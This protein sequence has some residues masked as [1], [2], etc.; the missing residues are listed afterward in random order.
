[1][2]QNGV[3]TTTTKMR[4]SSNRQQVSSTS[5]WNLVQSAPD[6][7]GAQKHRFKNQQ[8]G[9]GTNIEGLKRALTVAELHLAQTTDPRLYQNIQ[10]GILL[11]KAQLA[12]A[13]GNDHNSL[14]LN[15]VPD[16]ITGYHFAGFIDGGDFESTVIA[17]SPTDQSPISTFAQ[18]QLWGTLRQKITKVAPPVN[19]TVAGSLRTNGLDPLER[20]NVIRTP[21]NPTG[22]GFPTGIPG[23]H[24]EMHTVHDHRD[25]EYI[26]QSYM[27]GFTKGTH[28][29]EM[30]YNAQAGISTS[31]APERGKHGQFRH[32]YTFLA[33]AP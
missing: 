29:L 31:D 11:I 6:S 30:I 14:D 8:T 1:M 3:A 4:N 15:S 23:S 26:G 13:V 32:G 5:R 10:H 20:S 21:N 33:V 12:R 27:Q 18:F 25:K 9:K 28:N 2:R 16:S 7:P 19:A 24:A 22:S 17:S